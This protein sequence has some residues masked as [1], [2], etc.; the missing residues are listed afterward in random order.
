MRG[1]IVDCYDQEVR[2][3]DRIFVCDIRYYYLPGDPGVRYY[4]DGTG[5]PPTGPEIYIHK[6]TV[7]AIYLLDTTYV[8][9]EWLETSGWAAWADNTAWDKIDNNDDIY[10]IL[11]ENAEADYDS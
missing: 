1:R 11:C 2:I 6:V 3:G 7:N 5:C 8:D 4:P 9:R 10:Y